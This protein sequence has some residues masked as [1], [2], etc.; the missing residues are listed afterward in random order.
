ME[1]G[2]GS[3]LKHAWNAFTSRDPTS[4]SASYGDSYYYRPDRT[5]RT[6]TNEKSIVTSVLNR[7]ALDAAAIDIRHCKLDENG[8]FKEE[9]ESG[10]NNCLSLDA[11]TDQTGR[12]FLQDVVIK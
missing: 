10:L 9:I 6:Y 4:G 1:N 11:N 2:F 7:I 8:R 12:A 5:R 3:R